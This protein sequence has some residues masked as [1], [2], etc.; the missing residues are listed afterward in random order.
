MFHTTSHRLA[1]PAKRQNEALK[2]NLDKVVN[3]TSIKLKELIN[4]K[5]EKVRESGLLKAQKSVLESD[6]IYFEKDIKEKEEEIKKL[7]E[8]LES[9]TKEISEEEKK[10]K[11]ARGQYKNEN[12]NQRVTVNS[13]D[14]E[15]DLL[16]LCE[17]VEDSKKKA[18]IRLE[19]ENFIKVKNENKFLEDSMHS[20]RREL[21]YL[22]VSC[23][24]L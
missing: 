18:D 24:L 9:L 17:G 11:F 20:L 10:Y 3:L 6:V 19:Y 5:Q 7:N 12:E 23:Y 13:V 1:F 21:F 2:H 15:L 8:D 14:K 16:L 4:R 22:E